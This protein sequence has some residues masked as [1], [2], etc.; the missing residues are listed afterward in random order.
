LNH[1]DALLEFG[2]NFSVKQLNSVS[3][4]K[5]KLTEKLFQLRETGATALGPS[6]TV[7]IGIASN[8]PRSKV[9]LC[10]D[11]LPNIGLGSMEDKSGGDTSRTFYHQLG[12]LAKSNGVEVSLLG[13]EGEDCG[14]SILGQMANL[15]GGEVNI[16]NPL[17]LQRNMRRIIDNPVIATDVKIRVI[18]PNYL[19][20]VSFGQLTGPEV[21]IDIGNVTAESDMGLEFTLG[22]KGI[23]ART[24]K[25]LEKLKSLPFQV[26]IQYRKLDSTKCLRVVSHLQPITMDRAVTEK[27]ADVAVLALSSVQNVA[28]RALVNKEYKEARQC[29]FSMQQLLDRLAQTDEQQE[30]YDIFVKV[31]QELDIE[32][33]KLIKNPEKVSDKSAKVFYNYKAAP[34]VMFL[35]GTRKDISKRKKHVG[36]LK[37]LKI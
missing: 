37:Q 15:T 7:A 4:S 31:S 12:A 26:Q 11:G 36:E 24:S 18:L 34:K 6:L 10:T 9:I 13:I 8:V 32:L 2:K 1:F 14:V 3:Q 35:A 27:E 33:E 30:E 20:F 17:E 22:E 23:A 29:L 19:S 28:A 25:K 16:V 21:N 5:E